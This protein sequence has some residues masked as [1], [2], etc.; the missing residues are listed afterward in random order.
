M[1]LCVQVCTLVSKMLLVMV[2]STKRSIISSDMIYAWGKFDSSN[3]KKRMQYFS[4]IT[5][6]VPSPLVDLTLGV[7][8]PVILCRIF[9]S[10]LLACK[11]ESRLSSPF[12]FIF[13]WNFNCVYY[14][15]L[16]I[17]HYL[18]FQIPTQSTFKWCHVHCPVPV[19]SLNGTYSLLTILIIFNSII[20]INIFSIQQGK[21]FWCRRCILEFERGSSFINNR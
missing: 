9:F 6:S 21:Y 17:F 11:H 3:N 10:T 12:N 5:A 20:T 7:N 4:S 13:Q 14:Y 15:I 18:E 16:T 8:F 1:F 2:I 19:C